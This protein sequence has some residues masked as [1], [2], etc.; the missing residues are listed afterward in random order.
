MYSPNPT[1]PN[2]EQYC[3]ASTSTQPTPVVL[4]LEEVLE[5]EEE[6]LDVDVL[7]VDELDV[8]EV[9][10]V[11]DVEDVDVLEVD[12]VDEDEVLEVEVDVEVPGIKQQPSAKDTGSPHTKKSLQPTTLP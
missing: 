7:D 5:V 11:E 8:D 6:V 12:E 4:E 10:E 3:V 2:T 9:L 1:S